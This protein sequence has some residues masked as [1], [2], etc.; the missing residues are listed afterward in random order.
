MEQ[1]KPRRKLS[2]SACE[3]YMA[4]PA[5]FDFYY[6]KKISPIKMGSALMF[7]NG[8]D[9]A[10]NELLLNTGV[11]PLQAYRNAVSKYELGKVMFGKYDFDA[12]LLTDEKLKALLPILNTVGYKGTDPLDLFRKLT[13]K[14]EPLSENQEKAIDVIYRA[15]FEAKAE[16]MLEAYRI[17]V[18]PFIT[19]VYNVQKASGPGF[20]DA[21]VEWRD[22]GRVILEHKTSGRPYPEDAIDYSA[23]LA[24]YAAEEN[25]K[26]VAFVVLIKE[27]QKNRRKVCTVCGYVGQGSHR[28]CD[29]MV[30]VHPQGD[31]KLRR[32]GGDWTVTISPEAEIQILHGEVTEQAMAVAAELQREVQRAVDAKIF[33][34]NVGQCNNQYGKQCEYKNLKW[35]ND[36]TGLEVRKPKDKSNETK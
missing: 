35:K 21:T 2:K 16:L 32:C 36:M 11:E 15:V 20:L 28:T 3:K 18:L 4:C 31:G 9:S 22:R 26:L 24:M 1:L 30:D 5:A 34:C 12:E 6:N 8:M 29:N 10:L 14:A 17:K 27:I 13:S 33:P 19:A 23:Q 7:G 25:V